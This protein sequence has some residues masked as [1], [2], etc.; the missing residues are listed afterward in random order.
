MLFSLKMQSPDSK[1]VKWQAVC[2]CATDRAHGL[3]GLACCC[4]WEKGA[5]L[6]DLFLM[7]K[8]KGSCR[9]S[10]IDTNH[11]IGLG[12]T[13]RQHSQEKAVPHKG[14][15]A[16]LHFCSDMLQSFFGTQ[17]HSSIASASSSS[18]KSVSLLCSGASCG[19][20]R[21]P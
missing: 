10:V 9:H 11:G 17:H 6:E 16:D 15:V 13:L 4:G 19:R 3:G 2:T 21:A 5:L 1:R 8:K 7:T 12:T 18:C 20:D 14:E